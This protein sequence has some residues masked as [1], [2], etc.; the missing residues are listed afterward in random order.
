MI[1]AEKLS[2]PKV[3]K[4]LTIPKGTKLLPLADFTLVLH[5]ALNGGKFNFP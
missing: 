1:S 3:N 2:L 5:N 4:H